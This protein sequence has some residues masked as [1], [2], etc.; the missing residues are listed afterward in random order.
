MDYIH[1]ENNGALISRTNYWETENAKRGYAYLS[2][3]AGSYRLL[4]PPGLQSLLT[5]MGDPDSVIISRGPWPAQGQQDAVELLFEDGTSSPY[6]LHMVPEQIDRFPLVSD[7]GWKGSFWIY[8]PPEISR[9]SVW[10]S[11]HVYYRVVKELPCLDQAPTSW[12]DQ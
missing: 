11:N 12:R 9:T 5:D 8:L 7:Q 1:I 3:N 4:V 2:I 10:A 6:C